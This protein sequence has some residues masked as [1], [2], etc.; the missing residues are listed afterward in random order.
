[1]LRFGYLNAVEATSRR[2]MAPGEYAY[3]LE[4]DPAARDYPGPSGDIVVRKGQVRD[5]GP[6]SRRACRISSWNSWPKEAAYLHQRWY[7]F[8]STF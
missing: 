7:E 3:W 5:G 2:F 6:L 8:A 4:G 1:M